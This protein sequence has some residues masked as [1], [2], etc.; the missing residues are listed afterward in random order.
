MLCSSIFQF[1]WLGSQKMSPFESPCSSLP[2]L[3]LASIS[4]SCQA[5][6]GDTALRNLCTHVWSR[7]THLKIVAFF[8]PE[9]RPKPPE[10]HSAPGTLMT[11]CRRAPSAAFH[12]REERCGNAQLRLSLGRNCS[13]AAA[14][15]RRGG[16][17]R[18]ADF[19]KRVQRLNYSNTVNNS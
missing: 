16:R 4:W 19:P 15:R 3:P 17:Q 2:L 11:Y 9:T 5:F 6:S 10:P 1:F 13:G 14:Q 12:L 8:A 18:E 7:S